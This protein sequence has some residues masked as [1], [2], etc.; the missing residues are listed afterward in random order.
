M[1]V[2]IT[3]RHCELSNE[4]KNF[5]KDRV[6]GLSR[7][8]DR[9]IEAQVTFSEEKHRQRA[10]IKININNSVIFSEAESPDFRQ[11]VEQV[12]QKLQRQIQK[13]KGRFRRRTL[14]KEDAASLGRESV[15]SPSM[16]EDIAFTGATEEDIEEMTLSEAVEKV[17][18]RGVSLLFRDRLSGRRKTVHRRDDGRIDVMEMEPEDAT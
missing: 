3:A 8:Y 17:K 13:H 6:I 4:Q 18:A 9:I 7:Y 5:I 15:L 16:E 12:I 14:T 11:T 2:T 10:E 1:N